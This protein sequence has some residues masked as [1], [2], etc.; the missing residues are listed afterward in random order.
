VDRL[1]GAASIRKTYDAE[2]RELEVR[3][4]TMSAAALD[5]VQQAIRGLIEND[6]S[7]FEPVINADDE[8]DFYYLEIE[9][10]VV[11]LFALQTPVAGDLRLLTALLHVNHSLER[12]A[13]MGV[14]LAKVGNLSAGLPRNEPVLLMIE[15]MSGIALRM[16]GAAMDSLARRDLE[17]AMKLPWM[18]DPLDRL[19]RSMIRAI[20]PLAN[21][22]RMLEWGMRMHVI[23]R[24]IERMGDQAVDIAE[25][26][27][28][29]ITGEFREF[30]DASHPE[31]HV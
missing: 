9:R 6:Q 5:M 13:D 15:E 28:F 3:I 2:L 16:L 30:T 26:V 10:R 29:V 19:N 7:L 25:Q 21:D 8:V 27:V 12:V 1:H 18:D 14:N 17:L 24:Q 31:A 4:Q 20:L 11:A 23:S 22:S